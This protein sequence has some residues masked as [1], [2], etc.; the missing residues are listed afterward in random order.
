[1]VSYEIAV[2]SQHDN[3]DTI[4]HRFPDREQAE[5]AAESLREWRPGVKAEVVE[6][7]EDPTITYG[8]WMER[9]W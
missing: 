9:G 1:M 8:Q 6:R 2:T 5:M 4:G 7:N 3:T